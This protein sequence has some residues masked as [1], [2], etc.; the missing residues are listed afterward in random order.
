M[1]RR[2]YHGVH[3]F[4]LGGV[5]LANSLN[6]KAFAFRGAQLRVFFDLGDKLGDFMVFDWLAQPARIIPIRKVELSRGL[7]QALGDL[8]EQIHI[9]CPQIQFPLGPR[10]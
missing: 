4:K 2:G 9:L 7:V 8:S 3:E 1:A 10:K 6:N 5:V